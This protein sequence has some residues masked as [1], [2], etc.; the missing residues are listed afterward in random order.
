MALILP[1]LRIS[2]A[3]VFL[4]CL[5]KRLCPVLAYSFTGS[6]NQETEEGQIFEAILLSDL[7]KREQLA[8]KGNWPISQSRTALME[9]VKKIRDFEQWPPEGTTATGGWLETNWGQSAPYN[10]FS[11]GSA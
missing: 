7:V 4:L 2:V 9:G 10:A 1:L 11:R 3:V 5:L 8:E 6:Y